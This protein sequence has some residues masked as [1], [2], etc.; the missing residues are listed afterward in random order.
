MNKSE[1]TLEDISGAVDANFLTG[2]CEAAEL[3]EA[4]YL[5]DELKTGLPKVISLVYPLISEVFDTFDR[6]PSGIYQNHYRTVNSFLDLE[7]LRL[8]RFIVN[9]GYKALPVPA[10]QSVEPLRGHLSHRMAAMLSGNGWIGKSA[11]LIT[12]N[13]AAKVRLVTVL[14]DLPLSGRKPQIPSRC[15]DCR[16]CI[17]VCPVK[18]I[19]DDPRDINR[20]ICYKYLQSLIKRDI[21]EELICGLCIKA[22]EP[23]WMV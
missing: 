22:C 19:Y 4:S 12:E 21:V 8:S 3:E 2:W 6:C 13:Y 18:A 1:F 5:D 17:D 14:T 15:A 16:K 11:L 9:L 10:S 7:A 20:E 23:S